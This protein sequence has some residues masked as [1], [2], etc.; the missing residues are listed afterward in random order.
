[1]INHIKHIRTYGE[2]LL[3]SDTFLHILQL[4]ILLSL[5]KYDL[6]CFVKLAT[7]QYTATLFPD[8]S[9]LRQKSRKKARMETQVSPNF[10]YL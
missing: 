8:K 10:A 4:I 6:R 3:R 9:A 2:L 5:S 7:V 1:M